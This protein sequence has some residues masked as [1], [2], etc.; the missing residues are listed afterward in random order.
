V[1]STQAS[2]PVTKQARSSNTIELIT[3]RSPVQV[4]WWT[5]ENRGASVDRGNPTR[6]RHGFCDRCLASRTVNRSEGEECKVKM[7]RQAG[8]RE[9]WSR[10][11]PLGTGSRCGDRLDTVKAQ[12]LLLTRVESARALSMSLSH[13][14]R[15]VQSEVPCVRSGRLRLYRPLDLE[16]WLDSVAAG[17][18][19]GP[20]LEG[21]TLEDVV[22]R[23]IRAARGCRAQ[24]V[25]SSLPST[26][27]RRP[28]IAQS[29]TAGDA[30]V[31]H[32]GGDA[33]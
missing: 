27:G 24:Q 33:R 17:P 23:F 1:R 15:H 5:G 31:P 12:R 10:S 28:G 6:A 22:E 9:A 25:A 26:R 19:C 7:P 21:M 32:R 29:A 4:P 18:I 13:F 20:S 3:R 14:Q 30:R 11:V 16:R 2:S 8:Q